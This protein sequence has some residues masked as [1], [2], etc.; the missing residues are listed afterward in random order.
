MRASA[1]R[2]KPSYSDEPYVWRDS[3]VQAMLSEKDALIAAWKR[4]AA[5]ALAAADL[6]NA[7]WRA[8]ARRGAEKD[9]DPAVVRRALLAWLTLE[10]RDHPYR[11]WWR[12]LSRVRKAVERDA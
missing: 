8:A 5:A 11:Y 9:I 12:G 7:R 6:A 4:R 10:R 3:V 1:E 2:E